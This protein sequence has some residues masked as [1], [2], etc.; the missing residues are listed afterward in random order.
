MAAAKTAKGG[1]Q[2][3]EGLHGAE[4]CG[5]QEWA[6]ILFKEQWEATRGFKLGVNLKS[7]FI[8][9]F[10]T[11]YSSHH[12]ELGQQMSRSRETSKVIALAKVRAG[13]WAQDFWGWIS[14]CLASKRS[15]VEYKLITGIF[16]SFTTLFPVSRIELA[17]G[18]HLLNAVEWIYQEQEEWFRAELG[19]KSK[20]LFRMC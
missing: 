8:F 4:L 18:R 16:V 13:G 6:W 9:E 12:V 17:Y 20:V 10:Y 19:K 1:C 3:W 11:N 15:F 5:S 7:M 14:H 2:W